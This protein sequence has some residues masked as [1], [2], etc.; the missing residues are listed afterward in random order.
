[1]KNNL[2]II[3]FCFFAI[4]ISSAQIVSIRGE[5]TN[6]FDVEGIHVLNQTSKLNTITNAQGE[7]VIGAQI[8]DTLLFSSVKYILQ[9]IVITEEN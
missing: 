8:N 9:E 6:D 5:V 3:I 4:H 7:F 1:M 2:P